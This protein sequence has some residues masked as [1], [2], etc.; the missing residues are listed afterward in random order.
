MKMPHATRAHPPKWFDVSWQCFDGG[1]CCRLNRGGKLHRKR[2]CSRLND[3]LLLLLLTRGNLLPD[4]LRY[5][6]ENLGQMPQRNYFLDRTSF[7]EMKTDRQIDT[8]SA[9]AVQTRWDGHELLC[10]RSWHRPDYRGLG[11]ETQYIDMIM[12]LVGSPRKPENVWCGGMR[13][14]QRLMS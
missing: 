5:V 2:R 12:I 8:A 10:S 9:V 7:V 1:C 11:H 3:V 13:F 4:P 14:V 6:A